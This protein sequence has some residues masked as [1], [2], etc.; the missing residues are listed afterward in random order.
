MAPLHRNKSDSDKKINHP[1]RP[2]QFAD[3]RG[4]SYIAEPDSILKRYISILATSIYQ[5]LQLFSVSL[6]NL[7][8]EHFSHMGL[9]QWD[10]NHKWPSKQE[11]H[12]NKY[13]MN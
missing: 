13:R 11:A 6:V 12:S 8:T 4:Y 10:K 3:W 2:T 5:L 7:E 9:R 1:G